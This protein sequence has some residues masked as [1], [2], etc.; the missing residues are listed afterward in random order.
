MDKTDLEDLLTQM[1][2]SGATTLHLL[3]GQPPCMR[4][5]GKLISAS[6][7]PIAAGNLQELTHD[8]LFED[9][10]KRLAE[11]GEVEVL[12]ASRSG[13]RFR[14]SVMMQG[15]GLTLLFRRLPVIT[16]TFEELNLPELF[17]CF[18]SFH[19][20]LVVIT[21]FFGSGKSTTLAALIDRL[22]R[23]SACHIV[24]IEDPIEFIHGPGDAL[25]HQREVGAHVQSVAEGIRQAARQGAEVIAVGE[26]YDHESLLAMLDASERGCLVL[27][28]F[29]ASSVV[30]A[31]TEMVALC[32]SEEKARVRV[33][34]AQAMRAMVTQMLLTG[35]GTDGR[36]PL[37]E[38]LINN[39]TVTR[40]LRAGSFQDLPDVMH[41]SRGL[42]M[43]TSDAGL[44]NLL[45]RGLINEE[46]A[47][48][49]AVDWDYVSSRSAPARIGARR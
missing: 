12:Y 2:Q 10:R 45:S 11:S 9:H 27:T 42:G 30:G 8:F 48:Y 36:L 32:P 37:F 17:N 47:L 43:Q 41:R 4:A 21:G 29:D 14:T 31:L 28:T 46:D 24:T 40:C 33:R 18:T 44:R 5:K 49:H 1:V 20:G 25:I 34:L 19:N 16:P 7:E 38:V 35:K 13:V 6:A 26:M 3:A 23:E 39:P 15:E 22:N